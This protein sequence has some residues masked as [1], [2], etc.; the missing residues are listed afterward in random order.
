MLFMGKS[1]YFDW[2]IFFNS[3]LLNYQRINDG[4]WTLLIHIIP[5]IHRSKIGLGL[6]DG[7]DQ[8]SNDEA[9]SR[10]LGWQNHKNDMGI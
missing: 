9:R 6:V 10:A 4:F 1:N 5:I 7:D 3:K 8:A 2:A